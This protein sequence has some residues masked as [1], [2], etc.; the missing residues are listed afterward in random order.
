MLQKP[1]KNLFQ[2]EFG[3][4][5]QFG[6]F[7]GSNTETHPNG[8][9]Y[10]KVATRKKSNLVDDFE[11]EFYSKT[12]SNKNNLTLILTQGDSTPTYDEPT[13]YL[14]HVRLFKISEKSPKK[15]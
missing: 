3:H 6:F 1:L 7:A 5:R 15:H 9:F 12:T 4:S 8:S 14:N 11:K 10:E 2:F 13:R